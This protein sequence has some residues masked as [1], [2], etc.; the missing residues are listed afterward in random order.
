MWLLK[1][2]SQWDLLPFIVGNVIPWVLFVTERHLSVTWTQTKAARHQNL[3]NGPKLLYFFNSVLARFWWS[4]M[5]TLSSVRWFGYRLIQFMDR[6]GWTMK[7][8]ILVF[9]K[10]MKICVKVVTFWKCFWRNQN[11]KYKL[12]EKWNLDIPV[13][14]LLFSQLALLVFHTGLLSWHWHG[15]MF[16]VKQNQ[17]VPHL[18]LVTGS[19]GMFAQLSAD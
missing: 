9:L 16:E 6:K 15:D 12:K 17:S 4:R 10:K 13:S 19:L 11:V 7:D 5:L 2:K 1:F 3:L 8:K 14:Q 18:T